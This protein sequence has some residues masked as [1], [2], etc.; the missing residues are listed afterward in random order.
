MFV[1]ALT[2]HYGKLAC[3]ALVPAPL[4]GDVVT[5]TGATPLRFHVGVQRT[6]YVLIGFEVTGSAAEPV[7]FCPVHFVLLGGEASLGT[8]K[9]IITK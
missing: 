3:S 5:H 4:R 8:L 9:T 2:A 7:I 6:I 1:R